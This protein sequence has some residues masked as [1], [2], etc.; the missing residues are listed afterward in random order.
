MHDVAVALHGHELIDALGA[1]ARHPAHV[2]AG[3]VDEHDVL[4]A[5]FRVLDEL[6]L[7]ATVLDVVRAAPARPG[8]RSRHDA[9]VEEL[10]HRLGRRPDDRDAPLAEEEHV[11]ARVHLAEHPV[12]VERVASEVEVESLG[13]HDLEGV[14]GRGCTP[15]QPRPPGGTPPRWCPAGHWPAG[16]VASGDG[17]RARG[18]RGPGARGRFASLPAVLG[19]RDRWPRDRR[20]HEARLRRRVKSTLSTRVT[21]WRQWSKAASSPITETTASGCPRSSGGGGVSRSISRTTS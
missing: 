3:Q 16:R 9:P 10:H 15:W 4:G 19:Q 5:L 20:P 18:A 17:R 11:R 13:E 21:R 7:E 1:K 14:T 6:G 12:D 8:D 2:V